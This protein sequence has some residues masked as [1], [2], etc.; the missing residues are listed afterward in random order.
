MEL[1]R[2]AAVIGLHLHFNVSLY[3]DNH[4]KSESESGYHRKVQKANCSTDL[5]YWP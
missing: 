3:S 4:N 5:F 1:R 2:A